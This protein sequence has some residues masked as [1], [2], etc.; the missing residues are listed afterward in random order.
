ME[1]CP[2]ITV[3]VGSAMAVADPEVL[4][5]KEAMREAQ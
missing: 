4:S 1:L 2:V 5:G 3:D